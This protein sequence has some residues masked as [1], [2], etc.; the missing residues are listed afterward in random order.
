M[1][2]RKYCYIILCGTIGFISGCVLL[3]GPSEPDVVLWKSATIP[4]EWVDRQIAAVAMQTGVV[5]NE[6]GVAP[7]FNEMAPGKGFKSHESFL[8]AAAYN[9]RTGSF[10][11]EWGYAPNP[12]YGHNGLKLGFMPSATNF[13]AE[14]ICIGKHPVCYEFSSDFSTLTMLWGSRFENRGQSA[15]RVTWNVVVDKSQP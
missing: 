2:L 4:R 10:S 3:S 14:G 7:Q 12:D 15:H 11:A 9:K 8:V 5:T 6:V 1:K 13:S